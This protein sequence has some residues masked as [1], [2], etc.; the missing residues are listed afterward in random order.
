MVDVTILGDINVDLITS[1]IRKYPEKDSQIVV[2][3]VSLNPGGSAANT[4]IACSRLGLKTRFIG[5]LAY[6]EFSEYL[7]KIL[8]K[9][10]VDYKI[11]RVKE[12][13]TG[14]TLAITFND[15]TRSFITF[16]GTN[17]TLSL[18]DLKLKD[19]KGKV[20]MV[21]GF[22]HLNALRKDVKYLY[23]YARHKGMKTGLDP[24]WDP[25]GWTRRRL[26]EIHEIIKV[27]DWLFPDLRE[28]RALTKVKNKEK[29]VKTLLKLGPKIVC[30]KLGEHGCLVGYENKIKHIKSF[31][32]KA[33]NPTGA[34]DVFT[35]AFIKGYLAGWDVEEIV[36]FANAAGALS[37]TKLGLERYPTFDEV[38]EFL[39]KFY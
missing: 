31:E 37:T 10:K 7:L 8:K 19:I 12:G 2:P 13:R 24:N 17:E 9:V 22:N 26:K 14:I 39:E 1:P 36:K 20:F 25:E 33:I 21:A 27:S 35:A 34:G 23:E 16:R 28:G 11:K 38:T 6:D 3:Y 32:V 15:E 29:I 18:N 30:L 4:A 5:K